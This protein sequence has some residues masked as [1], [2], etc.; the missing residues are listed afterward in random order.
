MK[1]LIYTLLFSI[2]FFVQAKPQTPLVT[3]VDISVKTLKGDVINL[4]PLLDQGKIVVIDFFSTSCGPC[5]TFAYD[6][7]QAYEGFGNNEGNVFFIAINYNGTNADVQF[8]DSL[9]NITLPSASGLDGGGNVAFEAFQVAAYPTVVVIKPD[10]SIVAPYV[11]EPTFENIT[12]EVLNA[13][14]TLVGVEE[15]TINYFNV[16]VFPNPAFEN[17]SIGFELQAA[18]NVSV[19]LKDILGKLIQA[20]LS[21][22]YFEKGNHIQKIDTQNLPS[23]MYFVELVVGSQ[24]TLRKL[25]INH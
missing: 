11:W 6:F 10:K 19:Q 21:N 1:R 5:Q 14:G 15:N 2:V 22:V 9:F 7:Q 23:G 12:Q 25:T 4:Y 20:P 18:D 24:T 8:F 17:A 16:N 13:G 3:A